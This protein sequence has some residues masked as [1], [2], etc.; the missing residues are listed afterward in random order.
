MDFFEAQDQARRQTKWL[1]LYFV[2]A[3]LGIVLAMHLLDGCDRQDAGGASERYF[4]FTRGKY[5]CRWRF[6]P[7]A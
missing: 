7:R 6:S 3:L 2:I 5:F 4:H 1:L